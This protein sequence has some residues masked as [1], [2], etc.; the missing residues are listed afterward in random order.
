M[1]NRRPLAHIVKTI[2]KPLRS[3]IGLWSLAVISNAA[4]GQDVQS[5]E[6]EQL[7]LPPNSLPIAIQ[8]QIQTLGTRM[9]IAHKGET[10]LDAQFVDDIGNRKSIHVV[11]QISGLVRIEGVHDKTAISFDGE[12]THNVADRTDEALMDTF[13]SDTTEAM[14]YS[15]RTGASIVLLGHDFQPV[16]RTASD[17]KGPRYDIYVVT[18]PDRIRGARTLQTRRFYFDSTTGLLASTRYSD[19]AGVNVETRFLNWEHIDGSGYP[20][21]V[22]RYENGRFTFSIISSRVTGQPQRNAAIIK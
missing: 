7:A 18:A 4:Q 11:H 1:K 14:F 10:A 6:R 16:S 12:F 20:T 5:R 8:S 2:I 15:A 9:R 19:S 13:V 17:A 3:I 22:E 21:T